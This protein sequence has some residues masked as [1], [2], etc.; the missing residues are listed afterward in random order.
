MDVC[1]N[2]ISCE[3]IDSNDQIDI[4]DATNRNNMVSLSLVW[5]YVQ[6]FRDNG[7]VTGCIVCK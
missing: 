1:E 2:V 5:F 7:E 4:D 6:S 3:D